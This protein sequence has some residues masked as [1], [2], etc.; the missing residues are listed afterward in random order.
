MADLARY[1]RAVLG[2]Y[3]VA[4]LIATL[5][6]LPSTA[7]ELAVGAGLDKLVH[8]VL[9]GGLTLVLYWNLVPWG[10]ASALHVAGIPALLAG[11]IELVQGPLPYR[12]GDVW[13]LVWGVVGAVVGYG[14]VRL[15]RR[16]A[17]R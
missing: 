7:Y 4:L 13:D 1:R 11:V 6:P 10:G 16:F 8:L 17:A 14:I 5:A 15:A 3:L 2:G 12:S 9:F